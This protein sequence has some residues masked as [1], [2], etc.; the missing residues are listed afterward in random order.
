MHSGA[1]GA[2]LQQE[3]LPQLKRINWDLR[4]HIGHHAD[5]RLS[6]QP[7]DL[8]TGL[9]R[10][11]SV[12][13]LLLIRTALRMHALI[14]QR[15][16]VHARCLEGAVLFVRSPANNHLIACFVQGDNRSLKLWEILRF[17]DLSDL[18]W[19]QNLIL[20]FWWFWFFRLRPWWPGGF[21]G[22]TRQLC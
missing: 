9:Q 15:C 3:R 16:F 21:L 10:W 2:T 7:A 22:H 12:H 1:W 19:L 13:S 17:W 8:D 14:R 11:L 18:L 4:Q 6:Q 20:K 5:P